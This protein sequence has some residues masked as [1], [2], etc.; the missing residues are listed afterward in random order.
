MSRGPI[1]TWYFALVVVRRGQRFLLTQERKYGSTWSIP[2][3]RVEPRETL[4]AAAIREVLEETG[5]PVRIDGILRIEH[6]PSESGVRMRVLFSGTPLD[7]TAPKTVADDESLGAAWLT[8]DE[9][10]GKK[11]RGA[12]LRALL[13]TVEAGRQVFPLE[14]LGNTELSI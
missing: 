1:P 4:V 7:D 6:V 13:E 10:R 9:I 2:G 8:L 3:G 12:E 11:L 5:V 14:L